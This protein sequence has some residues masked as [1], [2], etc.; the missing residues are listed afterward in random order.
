MTDTALSAR[1]LDQQRIVRGI[2]SRLQARFAGTFGPETIERFA[3]D[4][5]D[6]LLSSA[7]FTTYLP[8]L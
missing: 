7:K 5:L 1:P 2:T 6:K 4:S 8:L 3:L